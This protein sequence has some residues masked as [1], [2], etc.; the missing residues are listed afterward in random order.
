MAGFRSTVERAR[1]GPGPGDRVH[2]RRMLDRPGGGLRHELEARDL[3][4][5]CE[6]LRH[7][8]SQ[9]A[10]PGPDPLRL[11]RPAVRRDPDRDAPISQAGLA[12]FVGATCEDVAKILAE[13]GCSTGWRRRDRARRHQL[14]L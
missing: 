3:A 9:F 8:L 5:D 1:P 14:I 7:D 6:L 13:C 2:L 12:D 11:L 4:A 10:A